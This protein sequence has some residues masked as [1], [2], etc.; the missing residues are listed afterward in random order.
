MVPLVQKQTGRSSLRR[1][2]V[3]PLALLV[4]AAAG[5]STP[6]LAGYPNSRGHLGGVVHVSAKQKKCLATAIYFEARSE[7]RLGQV[8]VAQV[9]LNRVRDDAYPDTICDVVFQNEN[10]RNACQFSFACDGRSDKPSERRAWLRAKENAEEVLEGHG[11]IPALGTAT[12]YHA[13][14]VKPNWA[15]KM[16]RLSKIGQHIFYRS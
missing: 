13:A 5:M 8:G 15:P 2:P 6:A 16:T 3:L 14:Y 9:I 4:C 12:H 1:L 7:S 10:R 11:L